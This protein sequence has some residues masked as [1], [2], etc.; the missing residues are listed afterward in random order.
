M[1]PTA[2]DT[3]QEKGMKLQQRSCLFLFIL[4]AK[5]RK[6]TTQRK[7]KQQSLTKIGQENNIIAGYKHKN[8]NKFRRRLKYGVVWETELSSS[9]PFVLSCMGGIDPCTAA[10]IKRL[11]AI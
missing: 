4:E 7:Q 8:Y 1:Q 10:I 3:T 2:G 11:E 5:T 9:V 6:G